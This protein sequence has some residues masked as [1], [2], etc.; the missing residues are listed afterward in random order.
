[1][2]EGLLFF[3]SRL[4]L[5]ANSISRCFVDGG[6]RWSV[7]GSSCGMFGSAAAEADYE[8]SFITPCCPFGVQRISMVAPAG[9]G[10][11]Q[12]VTRTSLVM[13]L[14]LIFV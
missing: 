2:F 10:N 3:L 6:Q 12:H 8:P 4:D 1:M 14:H 11:G 9:T 5:F 7:G 13:M